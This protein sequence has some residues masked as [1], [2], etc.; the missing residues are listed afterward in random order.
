[1]NRLLINSRSC[2]NTAYYLAKNGRPFSDFNQLCILQV[3]NGVSLGETHLNDKRCREFIEAI[4]EGMKR[5][6][7]EAI[8]QGCLQNED[9]RPKNE[10]LI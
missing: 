9:R 8:K 6:Q 2:L 3:K 10:E 5:D 7:K 1:M 4:A